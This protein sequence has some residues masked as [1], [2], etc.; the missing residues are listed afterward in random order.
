M[1]EKIP[2][3]KTLAETPKKIEQIEKRLL[4]LEKNISSF[5]QKE[6]CPSCGSENFRAIRS[7]EANQRTYK[8]K[9]CE[10]K[11]TRSIKNT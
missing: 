9:D 4:E 11:E 6:I 3:W 7:R 8:C 1:L 10:Y 5:K 2:I